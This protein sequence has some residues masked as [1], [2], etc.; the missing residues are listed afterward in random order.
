[1]HRLLL[2]SAL[3]L[4]AFARAET[5]E[6]AEKAEGFVA[7]FN[8]TDFSG[9]RFD[10]DSAAGPRPG[11]WTVEGGVIKLA[12]GGRPHLAS[13]WDY[14]DFDVRLQWRSVKDSYNSGFFVR[15]GRLVGANQ[16]NL[17]KAA[18]GGFIGGKLAG[19]KPV[20]DLQQPP[21]QWN[22]WRVLAEGDRLTFWCNGKLAWTGTGLAARRG[23]LGLQAEGAPMEFRRLRIRELGYTPYNDLAKD[24][25]GQ[26]A[27]KRD[28]D[29]FAAGGPGRLTLRRP[30][31][32]GVLRLEWQAAKPVRATVALQDGRGNVLR[33]AP[34]DLGSGK[35]AA[36][37]NPAGEWNY[38]E[39]RLDGG[40]AS[41]W[42][43]GTAVS[44]PVAKAV[45]PAAAT[46]EVE[47]GAVRLRNL[48]GKGPTNP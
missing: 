20:P 11:N 40:K 2:L 41:A 15:S 16:I 10:K 23:Y 26:G 7:L 12:G 6:A 34:G 33:V 43:N 37:A 9:W 42:L 4:P 3:A 46:V 5:P 45:G 25:D 36:R 48:R 19:A 47:A 31:A 44:L 24:W 18:P 21:K 28:G 17:A 29:G 1:M 32:G 35:V 30:P 38:L 13:Q 8:G 22:D 14:E 27:W 39:L